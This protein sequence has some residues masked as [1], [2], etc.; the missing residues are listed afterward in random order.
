MDA[1][2]VKTMSCCVWRFDECVCVCNIKCVP[3][4]VVIQWYGCMFYKQYVSKQ[5]EVLSCL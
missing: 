4:S 3:S 1:A 2:M 5:T